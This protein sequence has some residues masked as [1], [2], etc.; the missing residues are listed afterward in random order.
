MRSDKL[1]AMLGRDGRPG[2]SKMGRELFRFDKILISNIFEER[3]FCKSK[4]HFQN[5]GIKNIFEKIMLSIP[6]NL[7]IK[8]VF[9]CVSKRQFEALLGV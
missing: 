7:I 4:L 8:V 6:S 2:G 5:F 9:R 3:L 1:L